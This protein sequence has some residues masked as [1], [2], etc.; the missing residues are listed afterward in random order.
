VIPA[1]QNFKPGDFTR[2]YRYDRLK[3]R[4]E[5]SA[6]QSTS[7]LLRI[8]SHGNILLLLS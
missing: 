1:S 8:G 6:I 4:N 2:A 5:L 7:D 3:K